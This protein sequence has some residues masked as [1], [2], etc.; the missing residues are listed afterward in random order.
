MT[1]TCVALSCSGVCVCVCLL[2]LCSPCFICA[3]NHPILLPPYH[4]H[5]LGSFCGPPILVQACQHIKPAHRNLA[6]QPPSLTQS[7]QLYLAL[8]CCVWCLVVFR[9]LLLFV[10]PCGVLLCAMPVTCLTLTCFA[11]YGLVSVCLPVSLYAFQ[12]VAICAPIELVH[13]S[14]K[15]TA[16][17]VHA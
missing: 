9:F 13:I 4:P 16:T 14:S 1:R 15:P 3:C 12:S 6:C 10:L 2:L 7:L 5:Y 17:P 8:T 11:M